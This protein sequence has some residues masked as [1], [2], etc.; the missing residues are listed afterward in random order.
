MASNRGEPIV[1]ERK[2]CLPSI[3]FDNTARRLTGEK[4]DFLDLTNFASIN[5]VKRIF[6]N[7]LKRSTY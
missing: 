5:P 7:F 2:V 4:I 6:G 1:L 3:A